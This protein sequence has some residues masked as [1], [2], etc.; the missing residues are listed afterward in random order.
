MQTYPRF[1]DPSNRLTLYFQTILFVLDTPDCSLFREVIKRLAAYQLHGNLTPGRFST[2]CPHWLRR[3]YHARPVTE[4]EYH[5]PYCLSS[6]YRELPDTDSRL[7]IAPC[8][9]S[10][11]Q[12]PKKNKGVISLLLFPADRGAAA[13]VAYAHHNSNRNVFGEW[14]FG[15]Q[16]TSPF[17]AKRIKGREF[18]YLS[19]PIL[20]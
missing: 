1:K 7:F 6:P 20:T 4:Q 17:T 13:N 18:S 19:A 9:K 11:S 14:V 10:A 15:C 16:G 5:C 12:R 3:S 8:R 2:G